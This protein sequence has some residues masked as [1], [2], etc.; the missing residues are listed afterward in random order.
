MH[1]G[2][3][4]LGQSSIFSCLVLPHLSQSG[5]LLRHWSFMW[6][7]L[8]QLKHILVGGIYSSRWCFT[9]NKSTSGGSI[10]PSKVRRIVRVPFDS[11]TVT[12]CAPEEEIEMALPG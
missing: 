7:Y 4:L 5:V 11:T 8:K 10:S 6:P 3:F 1:L 9:K 2:P 12:L